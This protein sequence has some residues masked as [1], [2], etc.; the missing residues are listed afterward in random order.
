[1]DGDSPDAGTSG[2]D[3]DDVSRCHAAGRLFWGVRTLKSRIP[4]LL[5]S[6]PLGMSTAQRKT[7][8]HF[9]SVGGGWW[10]RCCWRWKRMQQK[11]T[12]ETR[13][14][15]WTTTRPCHRAAARDRSRTATMSSRR[16]SRRRTTTTMT[17]RIGRCRGC[18]SGNSSL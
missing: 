13:S 1:M 11:A 16:S 15:R 2:D 18:H 9:Y 6:D 10:C 17:T 4:M 5:L 8:S 14:Q 12:S 7:V 3:K